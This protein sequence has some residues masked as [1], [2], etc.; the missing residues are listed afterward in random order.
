MLLERHLER[1][2][3]IKVKSELEGE[4]K[5]RERVDWTGRKLSVVNKEGESWDFSSSWQLG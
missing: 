2:R 1:V 4:W 3:K 5:K